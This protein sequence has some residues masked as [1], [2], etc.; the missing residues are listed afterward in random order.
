MRSTIAM[1]VF[2]AALA[3]LAAAVDGPGATGTDQ[4]GS[5]AV[6]D[7]IP[8]AE[9]RR[10]NPV[11]ASNESIDHGKMLFASQCAMC[12]GANGDGKGEL[13][14]KLKLKVPDMTDPELQKKRTDGEWFYILTHGHG[15]M[16]GE[17]ERLPADWR[18]DMINAIRAM[19][20]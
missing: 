17:G 13:A 14:S 16:P 3:V 4:A 6:P 11:P 1:L 10:R 19:S 7:E 18:W 20:R 5:A 15:R 12:H 2:L 9:K 8:D